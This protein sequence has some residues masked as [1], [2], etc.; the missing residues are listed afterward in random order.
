[1]NLWVRVPKARGERESLCAAH[2]GNAL[3][4]QFGFAYPNKTDHDQNGLAGATL[5]NEERGA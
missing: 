1:M 2:R 3:W 5:L 4:D